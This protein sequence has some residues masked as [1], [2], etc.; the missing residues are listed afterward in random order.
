MSEKHWDRHRMEQGKQAQGHGEALDGEQH[1]HSKADHHAKERND[2]PDDSG[3]AHHNRHAEP[4][5]ETAIGPYGSCIM[6][7]LARVGSIWH[8]RR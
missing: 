4:S 2:H 3:H 5:S 8:K 6:P 1:A 7:S